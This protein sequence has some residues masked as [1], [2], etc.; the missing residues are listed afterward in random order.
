MQKTAIQFHETHFSETINALS[1]LVAIPSIS[2][3]GYPAQAVTDSAQAVATLMTSSGLSN[4][5]VITLPGV[6]P[7]VYGEHIID[8]A[9]PTVLLYAHHDVQPPMRTELW[10]SDPFV[11]TEKEGRLFGRGTADD[12]AGIV[13]H[14]ASIKALLE[15]HTKLHVN[16]KVLIEGEEEIGS[17]HLNSFIEHYRNKLAADYIVITDA[18]NYDTGK[19]TLTTCLRGMVCLDIE[20]SALKSP[21]HSGLW[22]GPIP[23]PA[24]GLSKVLASL[25][26]SDGTIALPELYEGLIEPTKEEIS[27]Y[28]SLLMHNQLFR[29]QAGLLEGV[30]LFGDGHE[31]LLKLWKEPSLI[32][33]SMESG[34]RK[35]AGNVI[36]NG[37]WAR[38]GVRLP[39]GIDSTKAESALI[40]KIKGECPWGLNLKIE[41]EA[42]V[43]GWATNT[44]DPIFAQAKQAL[45]DGYQTDAVFAGCG[46]SIPL[47]DE[48][49]TALGG[50]PTL[51]MGIEDPYTNAHSENESLH[52]DD[53]RKAIKSQI[54]FLERF[55]KI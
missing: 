21:L 36:M 28:K 9:Y 32:I 23:D 38:V 8:P 49:S 10:N 27:S 51:L 45:T 25:T 2:F 26:Q 44:N 41:T 52:L 3:D 22:G 16:I 40:S 39:A 55:S 20:V 34:S 4:V 5:E 50:I 42:A 17:P 7:Y 6:H 29:E 54:L 46:A 35:S 30:E 33:N 43:D 31:I 15:T 11:A 12:K 48:L 1:A 24:M 13:V 19:P 47:A 18:T 14:T 37:A 53:F